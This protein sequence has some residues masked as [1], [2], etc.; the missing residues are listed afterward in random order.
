M[1]PLKV[2][3]ISS[4][5]TFFAPE[6]NTH[7]VVLSA[8]KGTSIPLKAS[9]MIVLT[10]VFSSLFPTQMFVTLYRFIPHLLKMTP[11]KKETTNWD[12]VGGV[13]ERRLG[14]CTSVRKTKCQGTSEDGQGRLVGPGGPLR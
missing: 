13:T 10:Q 12:G 8:G 4:F 5:C 14:R 1:H 9:A 11:E 6:D 3:K 2:H 7:A